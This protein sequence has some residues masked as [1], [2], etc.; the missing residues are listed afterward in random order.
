MIDI[1]ASVARIGDWAFRDCKSLAE[2]RFGGNAPEIGEDA[3]EGVP[4]TCTAKVPRDSTGWDVD[5]PGT[6]NGMRIEYSSSIV[7]LNENGGYVI[8]GKWG[9]F[10]NGKKIGS[11]PE[12]WRDDGYV[13]NGWWTAKK[14][15]KR[16][17]E[18]TVV[19]KDITLYAHWTPAWTVTLKA[20]GGSLD[21]ADNK[22]PFA[23]GKAIGATGLRELPTPT[24]AGYSFKGW[25]T[26]KSGGTKVT[27]KTKV[28]KNVTWYAQWTVKKYAVKV[29]KVGKGTVTGTGSKAYKSK[30][31]LKAKAAKGYVFQGWYE[32]GNGEQ[33][34]GN[35]E[36][37]VSRKASYSFTVPVGGRTLVVKF[38][39]TAQDKAGIG[40]T[41]DGVG[42]GASGL[43]GRETLP[44]VTNVC[45]VAIEAVPIAASGLTPVSITV[46]GL[47]TGLKYDT[48]K[49]TI[50]GVPTA[51]K[52]FTAKVTVKS[53]GASRSWSVK[54]V[55]APLPSWAVGTFK[56]I[57]AFK[58]K[59]ADVTMTVGK[60]GKISGKFTVD[61][62]QYS[63]TAPSFTEH[64]EN[65]ALITTKGTMKYGSKTYKVE[66]AVTEGE[67][68]SG[69]ALIGVMNGTAEIA[70]G[71]LNK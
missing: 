6:W 21:G 38:L 11:L 32:T 42:V 64:V 69:V 50:T 51:A 60:T 24:R 66:I 45:G 37:L 56:G 48:K 55:V 16:V 34:T 53:L 39:T 59:N 57:G 25:Y 15:G 17:T 5:I 29:T 10:E 26:K 27:A 63:F 12:A 46:T 47:P 58:E 30:V 20:N 3:F 22:I 71:T 14:G 23:K 70:G 49:K 4:G 9:F 67:A 44:A 18:D 1:P 2:V 68:G 7:T 62:K 65:G 40:L 35:G 13:F 54:W 19:T 33:E 61:G 43:A 36:R 8:G 28:T 52:S 31:T 41:V